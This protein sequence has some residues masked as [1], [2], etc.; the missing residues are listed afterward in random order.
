[1]SIVISL[2]DRLGEAG[3]SRSALLLEPGDGGDAAAVAVGECLV[4]ILLE[5]RGAVGDDGVEQCRPSRRGLVG[6]EAQVAERRGIVRGKPAVAEGEPVHLDRCAV[7]LDRLFDRIGRDRH[8]T[9]LIG[10]TQQQHVGGNG[11]TE[12]ALGE[13]VGV[14]RVQRPTADLVRDRAAQAGAG[15]GQ[16]RLVGEV[17]GRHLVSRVDDGGPVGSDRL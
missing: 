15:N 6:G 13:R 8:V 11:V 9:E 14:D 16:V 10:E 7:E 1:M 5:M 2:G 3:R 4:L 17:A 12:Q